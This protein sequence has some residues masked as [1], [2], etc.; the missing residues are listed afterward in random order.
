MMSDDEEVWMMDIVHMAE[1]QSDD[2]L[3]SVYKW[4]VSS[5]C[6]IGRGNNLRVIQS[7][8]I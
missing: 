8:L 7:A 3:K 5:V 1:Q 2:S 4:Y 6:K